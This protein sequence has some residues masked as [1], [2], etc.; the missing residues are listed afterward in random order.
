MGRLIACRCGAQHSVATGTDV[1]PTGRCGGP[2]GNGQVCTVI[3]APTAWVGSTARCPAC[4]RT[5]SSMREVF[6][7]SE[8]AC[9][10]CGHRW[11][12]K[13]AS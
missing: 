13:A 5:A 9:E 4:A 7:L 12:G 11:R 10:V 1:V 6:R 2:I 8:Y 3:A